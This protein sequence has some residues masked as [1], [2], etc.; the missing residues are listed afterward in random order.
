VKIA[1]R[2]QRQR[3]RYVGA[4]ANDWHGVQECDRSSALTEAHGHA[5]D[6]DWYYRAQRTLYTRLLTDQYVPH[7]KTKEITTKDG[8][9]RKNKWGVRCV[10]GGICDYRS[11][12]HELCS[13]ADSLPP[14]E[15]MNPP[16]SVHWQAVRRILR[17]FALRRQE[18]TDIF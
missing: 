3:A 10:R 7:A 11:L 9:A 13:C 18:K 4:K 8:R 12:L 14:R 5:R 17:Y 15:P 2:K 1:K 6:G 16:N